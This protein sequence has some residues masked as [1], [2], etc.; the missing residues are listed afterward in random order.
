LRKCKYSVCITG[1]RSTYNHGTMSI[2]ASGVDSIGGLLNHD[3]EFTILSPNSDTDRVNYS[4]MIDN[5]QFEVVGPKH[6]AGTPYWIRALWLLIVSLFSYKRCD[7]VIDMRGEGYVST[8]VA[9]FQSLQML[10]AHSLGKPFV[11]YAQSIGPFDT[12]FSRLLAKITLERARLIT[13][14][15]QVSLD[16]LESLNINKNLH[17]AADQAI[18][19][20][21]ISPESAL[22]ILSTYG[23]DKAKPVIGASV[24]MSK[25]MMPIM[26]EIIDHVVQRH[27]ASVILLPHA[28]D[29]RMGGCKGGDD[30]EASKE[31]LLRARNKN[32]ISV[33]S[34]DYTARE[35]KGMMQCC[36]MYISF[37]WHAAIASMSVCNPTVIVGAAHKSAAVFQFG[38]DQYLR[39]PSTIKTEELK[40]VV[41]RCWSERREIRRYLV[42]H[43]GEMKALAEKSAVLTAEII[44]GNPT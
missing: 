41:D 17:L 10:I 40:E 34:G 1:A 32:R 43:R 31:V 20:E 7:I 9:F 19:L 33:I 35:I 36:D 2:I 23:V 12:R 21:P 3:V 38:L 30:L 16:S 18:L 24:V 6:S 15:E 28:V 27:D 29:M 37:R 14:R 39:D 26:T 44:R 4:R 11:I 13:V 25:N 42:D 22:T 8:R 5:E